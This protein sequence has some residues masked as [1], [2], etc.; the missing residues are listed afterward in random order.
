MA[1]PDHIHLLTAPLDRE[2]S[3]A[4][5]L[6]WFKRWFNESFGAREK[7]RWQPGGFDRLLRTSESIHEK[8]NYIREIRFEPAWSHTGN[9]GRIKKVLPTM[10]RSLI[11]C[12]RAR[13]PRGFVGRFCETPRGLITDFPGVRRGERPIKDAFK[14]KRLRDSFPEPLR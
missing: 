6:K 2:L 13:N 9:S 4:A 8:W 10:S 5:F 3:V 7:W 12:N 11:G 1:M 14:R